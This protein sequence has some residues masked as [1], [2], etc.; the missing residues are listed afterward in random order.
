M[1]KRP[2][3]LSSGR[4]QTQL[5]SLQEQVAEP[6]S[7]SRRQLLEAIGAL[8]ESLQEL[9]V[10]EAELAQQNEELIAA[11]EQLEIERHRY[12]ELFEEAPF[13]Y[14][15]TDASGMVEEAN[16]AAAVLFSRQPRP[17]DAA[18]Q[19]AGG[20]GRAARPAPVPRSPARAEVQPGPA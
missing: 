11:R 2:A 4:L 19:A 14:L 17:R 7:V 3:E 15:V 12:R 9:D 13:A 8:Q 6:S 20:P 5:K 1:T 10:A 16:V 18:G